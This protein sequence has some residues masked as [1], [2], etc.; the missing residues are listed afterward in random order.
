MAP[1]E[2]PEVFSA[3]EM[4]RAA[5]ASVDTISNLVDAGVIKAVRTRRSRAY[6][7]HDEAIRVGRAL[8]RGIPISAPGS[9]DHGP[10]FRFRPSTSRARAPFAVSSVAH[11]VALALGAVA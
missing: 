10:L 7:D 2:L 3:R 8:A 5:G 11:V 9:I 1:S 6:L 4:A